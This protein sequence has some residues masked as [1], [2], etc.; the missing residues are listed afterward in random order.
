[1]GGATT[2]QVKRDLLQLRRRIERDRRVDQFILFGSRARGDELLTSDA[3]VLVVSPF[4]A[5]INFRHRPALVL[6]H[7]AD[8]VDLEVLCYTPEEFERLRARRGIVATADAE[9]IRL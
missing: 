8:R 7:W 1:M 5:G 3:D 4:F 2:E 9:G 6:E